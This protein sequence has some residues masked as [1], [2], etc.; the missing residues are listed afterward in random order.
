MNIRLFNKNYWLRRFGEQKIIRGYECST[1][2][3]SV[4]NANIHPMSTDKVNALPEGLRHMKYLEGH[5][6]VELKTA[7]ENEHKKGDLLF[8]HGEWYECIS[9]QFWDHTVLSHYNYQFGLVPQDSSDT[10]DL[11]Q[12]EGESVLQKE[13]DGDAP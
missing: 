1:Y 10:Y 8:Y 12:P 6:E 4:L 13:K 9:C 3:D 7:N 2:F 5:G 11:S